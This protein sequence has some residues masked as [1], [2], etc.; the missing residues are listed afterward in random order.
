ME[1]HAADGSTDAGQVRLSSRS[2]RRRRDHPSPFF[3][4]RSASASA[5]A[6]VIEVAN[7][8]R[9]PEQRFGLGRRVMCR[10]PTFI[11]CICRRLA[12][13]VFTPDE[14]VGEAGLA[15]LTAMRRAVDILRLDLGIDGSGSSSRT[16]TRWP[17][18]SWEPPASG[19]AGSWSLAWC[20]GFRETRPPRDAAGRVAAGRASGAN[21]DVDS[22]A[23]WFRGDAIPSGTSGQGGDARVHDAYHSPPRPRRVDQQDVGD[24]PIIDAERLRRPS[25]IEV[26]HHHRRGRLARPTRVRPARR[27]RC[28]CSWRRS[29]FDRPKQRVVRPAGEPAINML[30][31]ERTNVGGSGWSATGDAGRTATLGSGTVVSTTFSAGV[32]AAVAKRRTYQSKHRGRRLHIL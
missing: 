27:T 16:C 32:G 3:G 8:T 25:H 26:H 2:I 11:A 12:T 1:R 7:R 30:D 28:G 10:A 4:S 24:D 21:R 31:K 17:T 13:A 19:S 20:S 9:S 29:P 15:R 5:S 22:G 6:S 23:G 18:T 14:L